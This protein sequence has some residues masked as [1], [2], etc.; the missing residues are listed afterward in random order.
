MYN[1]IESYRVMHW[2]LYFDCTQHKNGNDCDIDAD[3]EKK[4]YLYVYEK[5][6][7]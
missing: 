6:P 3:L 4:M 1:H 5:F 7:S 2:H